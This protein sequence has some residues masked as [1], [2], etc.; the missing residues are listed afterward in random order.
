MPTSLN[1]QTQR[2]LAV[3]RRFAETCRLSIDVSSIEKRDPPEPDIL[4]TVDGECDVAFELV[5][6][7][8]EDHKSDT[9]TKLQLERDYWDYYTGLPAGLRGDFGKLYGKAFIGIWYDDGLSMR[10]KR[11]AIP[12]VFDFLR[13]QAPA[14]QGHQ[15]QDR[16]HPTSP[17]GKAGIRRITVKHRD[18]AQPEF[19]IQESGTRFAG[20]VYAPF[21]KKLGNQYTTSAPIE[22][23]AYLEL[24]P[25]M[26]GWQ[27]RLDAAIAAHQPPSAFRR[28]WVF[29]YEPP[30]VL[31]EF[32]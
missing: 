32:P 31:S 30:E 14:Y 25:L 9:N 28:V 17:L 20:P 18:Y 1:K 2:E 7:T 16:P 24:Q 26:T 4:C 12:V 3:F 5:E 6:V 23:L 27:Q 10:E 11:Q 21:L 22:L 19:D 13:E 15:G 29:R 8:D